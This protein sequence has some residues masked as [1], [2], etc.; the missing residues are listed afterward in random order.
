MSTSAT[1]TG[2][3]STRPRLTVPVH[4]Q[5]GIWKGSKAARASRAAPPSTQALKARHNLADYFRPPNSNT[6]FHGSR[7]HE[8]IGRPRG[9][10]PTAPHRLRPKLPRL[11]FR[12]L[13]RPDPT[14]RLPR[15]SQALRHGPKAPTAGGRGGRGS[16]HSHRRP[17]LSSAADN[18]AS[19]LPRLGGA[20]PG[21]ALLSP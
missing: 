21:E 19:G 17:G 20:A 8:A 10:D 11:S 6:R 18:S 16:Q 15:V 2:F 5:P 14:R 4:R 13:P 9:R 3:Q 12:G 1:R 7:T